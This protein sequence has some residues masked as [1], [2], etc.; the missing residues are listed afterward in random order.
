MER[1]GRSPTAAADVESIVR[2]FGGVGVDGQ[3]GAGGPRQRRLLALLVIRCGQVV[4]LDWLAEYLWD[5]AERPDAHAT[6]LRTY[7]SRL[8]QSLPESARDWIETEAGGYR[9]D[10]PP[11]AVEHLRFG[12]LRAEARDARDRGDPLRARQ[13]LD[14]AIALWRGDPFRE[15]EDLDWARADVEQLQ[16]DR[17]EALEER[18]EAELALG[19]HT[20]ITGELGA[21]VQDQPLRERAVRQYALALHRSGRT[22][23][24]LRIIDSFRNELAD[25]SGLDPSPALV[26][27]E[28]SLLDG[29]P[30]LGVEPGRPLRGYRLLDE[31]GAGAFAVVW[32][33]VQPSVDREVAIKQIR[34]EL[35][36]R[37]EFIRRFEV[38]AR[39]VARIEHP[40]IV[41]LI[42]YW[43]DPDSA[44]LVMR[45]LGGDTLERRLD[46]GPLSI[47]ATLTLADQIGA[48]LSAAHRHGVVHR[49]VKASNVLFDELG[50]AYLSDFGIALGAAQSDDPAAA[51][52]RGSPVYASPEQLRGES[53][54]PEADV[55]SLGVVLYECLTGSTP[56]RSVGAVGELVDRQL[57]EPFPDVRDAVD[58]ISSAV[59]DAVSRATAKDP[60]ERF[61][62]VDAFVEALHADLA[63]DEST[64]SAASVG[65]IE[66][67]YL[68]LR[69]FDDGDAD[70]FFGRD[71]L[72][73]EIV[74]RLA[75]DG[76]RSRCVVVIGPSGSGKSSVVRAGVVPALR[77]GAAP[78][79]AEW[80]TTAMRPGAD[81]YEAL[82]AALLRVAVNPPASLLDQLRDGDRGILRGVRRCLPDDAARVTLVVDQLEELFTGSTSAVAGRFLDALTVAIDDPATPIRLVAALRADYY[83]R[84]LQHP[85]FARVV[86]ETAI[87][88]TPLAPDELVS[89][90][91]EPA[92]QVGVGF[93]PGLVARIAAEAVGQPS[94]LPLLQYTLSELFDRR[95]GVVLTADDYDAVGG[96]DGALAVRAEALFSDSDPTR[97][98]AV[99]SVFGRLT[100]PSTVAIDVRRRVP[101]GDFGDD[102]S[103]QEVLT[104]FG[105]ARLLAFDHD[106]TS[107]EPT[108]E[109]AHE[110]LLRAWPRAARWLEEDR[111]LRRA[112][113]TIGVAATQ[114]DEGG[115][116][117]GDLYRGRRLDAALDVVRSNAEWLRSLDHEFVSASSAHAERERT[118]EQRRIGRLRRL[119]AVTAAALV[120]ALVAGS[121]ALVQQR[122]A[123]RQAQAAE[124]AAEEA[125]RQRQ[126]ADEQAGAAESAASSAELATL[127]SRS[128]AAA[129][130]D[131]EVGLLLALEARNRSPGPAADRALLDAIRV[132]ELGRQVAVIERLPTTDCNFNPNLELVRAR[133]ITPDGLREFGV[134][135][136][137]LHVLD[138]TSGEVTTRGTAPERCTTWYEDADSGRRWAGSVTELAGQW[139]GA[140]DG[141]WTPIDSLEGAWWPG[142]RAD[143]DDRLPGSLLHADY[144]AGRFLYA[145]AP[146]VPG[147]NRVRGGPSDVVVVDPETLAP[148]APAIPELRFDRS[149]SL[150][151]TA[152]DADAGLFAVGVD[153]L[154]VVIDAA[155]GTEQFRLSAPGRVTAAVFDADRD[156]V[157]AGTDRGEVLA[158][159]VVT[160]ELVDRYGLEE[161]LG[162]E[163]LG[164]RHDGVVVAVSHVQIGLFAPD[165]RALGVP[166]A[167]PPSEESRV[168]R[169]GTVVLVPTDDVDTI[170]VVD[171]TGSPLA[172]G[173]WT[174]D[175]DEVVAFGAGSAGIVGASGNQLIDLVA[176]ERAPVDLD[177]PGGDPFDPVAIQPERDGLLAWDSGRTVARWRD[178]RVVERIDLWSD[179]GAVVLARG[180]LGDDVYAGD[181]GDGFVGAGAAAVFFEDLVDAVYR[182]DPTPGELTLLS[183]VASPPIATFAVAPAPDGGIYVVLET[184]VVRTYDVLG[185]R[186]DEVETGLP[187]PGLA[188]VDPATGLLAIGGE[189][190]AAIV[191]PTDGTVR[192]VGEV[193]AIRSLGFAREGAVLVVIETDGTVRLWDVSRN[194]LIGTLWTGTGTAS[195]SPPWYDAATDTVW[196]ATS[197]TIMQFSLDPE[198]W[199]ARACELVSREL[200][201]E[202]W[203]RLVPGDVPQRPACA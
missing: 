112:V 31:V 189:H 70:R 66:N 171:P 108:V 104:R 110:A 5:D 106:P 195:P 147:S 150:P 12:R 48:A 74:G 140:A 87:E 117:A 126:V 116:Q 133:T 47:E 76:V 29:D 155:T 158:A 79:S 115:R 159:D 50:N 137:E 143:P 198:R 39:T 1:M 22:A 4:T 96:I 156:V 130:D 28:R 175:P 165:G 45:W 24:G 80:F 178:S 107:R 145:V 157:L 73:D 83:D 13:L 95:S 43:R 34:S 20:Q 40:F 67:P 51:L 9:F 139:T 78:G 190:G 3:V 118:A 186:A 91:S 114:W 177:L 135:G 84:P 64:P 174:V 89:A 188:V 82:E 6:R 138:L 199:A 109:V 153:G 19:R 141:G 98:A 46:D 128:T 90:I 172:E 182:F 170:L 168:R 18:W 23:E 61:P 68:G 42:D 144:V 113:D 121:V 10:A 17:L 44:Y 59:A 152:A 185:R 93:E 119:V 196:V 71:R 203:D 27:L 33:A 105:G 52:S 65:A 202:E 166:T 92:R 146:P 132:G 63:R 54:G 148:V 129:A 56:F 183:T 169:D 49:D 69:A 187:E 173:G 111:D 125:D 11:D 134:V 184:G 197:G 136:D 32:R 193:G 99:R 72:V 167:I 37:P 88:V 53:V 35:V 86:K 101:L 123:D 97:R 75:G 7:L 191:D 162:I 142:S 100:N 179:S 161:P 77:G 160:G 194:E 124:E 62:T 2:V 122:R 57:H 163:A 55:F 200:T 85:T 15:L 120:V 30:S 21:F 176:G 164:V 127:I 14:E 41:P 201:P 38:E 151:A 8:R 149:E 102:E 58:G 154:L 192:S 60:A 16:L 180:D 25:Q 94:P 103:V 36:S 181:A 26:E 131:P 81:A